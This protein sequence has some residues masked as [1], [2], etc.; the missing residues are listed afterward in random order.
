MLIDIEL[1]PDDFESRIAWG[2]ERY[3]DLADGTLPLESKPVMVA[4]VLGW[5]D[6]GPDWQREQF[7]NLAGRI[8][9]LGD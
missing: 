6:L 5:A 8:A 7:R 4:I 3:A 9:S 2:G 1:P